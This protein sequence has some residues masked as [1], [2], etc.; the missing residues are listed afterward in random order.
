[1]DGHVNAAPQGA[2]SGRW[3][4]LLFGIIQFGL[5]LSF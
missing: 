1:M 2:L 3:W 4:Q 5:K